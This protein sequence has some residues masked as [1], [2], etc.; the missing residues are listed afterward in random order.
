M[1]DNINTSTTEKDKKGLSYND[2]QERVSAWCEK[3]YAD[4]VYSYNQYQ[5]C[6]KNLDTGTDS[7]YKKDESENVDNDKD[8]ERI[9]GYYKKG[10]EKINLDT[11]NPN[12][13]II[14]DDFQK[15]TLYHY[16]KNKFLLSD[17]NGFVSID[18]DS[19]I[20]DEKEWQLVSLG[21][22]DESNVF[23]L[24]SKYGKFLMGTDDG[25]INANNNIL[26]T[27]C[28]WKMIKHNDNFAFKSV[29]HKKYLAPVGDD[30]I[31]TDGWNDN[32]L[33]VMKKKELATGKHLG[34]FDNSSL[35]L[36]KNDLLNTMYN[37]YRKSIDSK[38]AREYYKNKLENLNSLRDSQLSYL[39][40]IIEK[41]QNS[42][43]NKK[44][45]SDIQTNKI[46]INNIDNSL[47]ELE[48]YK[49]DITNLFTELKEKEMQDLSNLILKSDKDRIKNIN[50][51]KKT[52][53]DIETFVN[54]LTKLN[55]KTETDLN[56]LVNNLDIK[57]ENSNQ[58]GLKLTQNKPMKPYDELTNIIN[59]NFTIAKNDLIVQRRFYFLGIIEI[60]LII[61][62]I[63]F[64]I[65][66]TSNKVYKSF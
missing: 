7:Y 32:N 63:L 41:N 47:S 42:L 11:S 52:E 54:K 20:Q 56:N 1:S 48:F 30:I 13:P 33:W 5:D 55:K 12:I 3:L 39:I 46:T 36:Q 27:W 26:S 23:A 2:L 65:M 15:M 34:K 38:Y 51:A 24:R 58:L 57:L 60:I 64:F 44:N 4:G 40:E 31:L 59:T 17:E 19:D 28:Q 25:K 18:V 8:T 9:Y 45:N 66:Q 53:K 35:I 22:K 49:T 43:R 37:Y 61:I 21:K 16:K 62:M 10:K 6:L 14:E 50:L 29:I